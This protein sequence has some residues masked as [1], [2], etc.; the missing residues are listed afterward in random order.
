MGVGAVFV[1]TLALSELPP[2]TYP[3]ETQVDWLA[4]VLQPIVSFIVLGSILTRKYLR[5]LHISLRIHADK[6]IAQ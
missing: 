4:L 6:Y 2:P 5:C 3:P 1:S